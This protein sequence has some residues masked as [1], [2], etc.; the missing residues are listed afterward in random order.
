MNIK[1]LKEST[2]D[3][4][5]AGDLEALKKLPNEGKAE[6]TMS[7]CAVAFNRLSSL[8][9]P[10]ELAEKDRYA[11]TG[12]NE[13]ILSMAAKIAHFEADNGNPT[14]L[15]FLKTVAEYDSDF[16]ELLINKENQK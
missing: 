6:W 14:V 16:K 11:A 7:Y 15:N 4:V 10:F 3:L 13:D 5:E 8:E 9:W 2:L 1:Y 12:G